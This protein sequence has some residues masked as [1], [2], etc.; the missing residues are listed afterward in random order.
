[1]SDN[2]EFF[3]YLSNI[4][5]DIIIQKI[6]SFYV[7]R[8]LVFTPIMSGAIQAQGKLSNVRF[9]EEQ[10]IQIII[11][12]HEVIRVKCNYGDKFSRSYQIPQPAERK[13]NRGRKK[14]IKESKNRKIQGDGTCFNSQITLYIVLDENYNKTYKVKVF[15][16]GTIKIPGVLNSD[17]SDARRVIQIVVQVLKECLLTNV[18][19]ISLHATMRNYKFNVADESQLVNIEVL[20]QKFIDAEINKDPLI[21]G[22]FQIKYNPERY[23]GLSVKFTT[24]NATNKKKETTIKMFQSGKINIDGANEQDQALYYYNMLNEFYLQYEKEI[25]FTPLLIDS[26]SDESE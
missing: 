9:H 18:E 26:G 11:P 8:R 17:L 2:I 23:P 12:K 4:F 1:M 10:L 13:S 14:K 25:I 24:P 16:N 5:N 15:R 3:K 21:N 20:K 22:I 7:K 6:K 19:L